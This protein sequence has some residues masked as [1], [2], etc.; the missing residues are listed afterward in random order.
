MVELSDAQ[1]RRLSEIAEAAAER[2]VHKT[3]TA[4]GIDVADPIA[5]QRDFAMMREIG[6]FATSAD[7]RK[8][9]EHC[10]RWRL[11][12][13][14]MQEKGFLTLIGLMVTGAGA[15]LWLGFRDMLERH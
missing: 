3:L 4:I 1:I 5:A 9:L 7:F 8:D 10:R 6:G 13:E 14:K 15:A 12:M 2:A 11:T